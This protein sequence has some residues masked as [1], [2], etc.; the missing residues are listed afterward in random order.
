MGRLASDA[1]CAIRASKAIRA[2]RE[3]GIA[4]PERAAFYQW[5]AWQRGE[6]PQRRGLEP[7]A[8]GDEALWVT[9]MVWGLDQCNE[10]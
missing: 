10:C 7:L 6:G 8:A 1:Q 9:M 2:R 3:Y 4:C 5:L